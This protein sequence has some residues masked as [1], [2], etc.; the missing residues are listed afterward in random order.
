MKFFAKKQ[1]SSELS[2]SEIAQVITRY[3]DGDFSYSVN[4][5]NALSNAF[6]QLQQRL[7][8]ATPIENKP[9]TELYGYVQLLGEKSAQVSKHTMR[10]VDT[11][12]KTLSEASRRNT[13]L[14]SDLDA[15]V[16]YLET[17]N[18]SAEEIKEVIGEGTKNLSNSVIKLLESVMEQLNTK[19][20]KAKEVLS[21]IQEIGKGINLLALNAAI[22]AARAGEQGRGFAVVADEVRSL[23]SVTM[24]RAQQ[25]SEQLNFN[26]INSELEQLLESNKQTLNEFSE[27]I[28]H[29][30]GELIE[31]FTSI[32]TQLNSVKE[33][34][35]VISESIALSS[36]LADRIND[37]EEIASNLSTN[38]VTGIQ[39]VD[40][41]HG[42]INNALRYLGDSMEKMSFNSDLSTDRLEA[43]VQRGNIRVA[44]EP[45]FVGLSFR[46]N[47]TSSLS[48]LDVDYAH[49]LAKY[50]GVTCE[51]V[52]VPWDICT[53]ALTI[54]VNTNSPPADVIISAL[55]PSAEYEN[56]AYSETYTYLNWV[57]ARRKDDTSINGIED[58]NNKALG[59]IND[60]G[61]F[62]LL[63]NTGVRWPANKDKPGGKVFLSDLIAYSDQSRIHD[64][65]V[66]GTVDAFGVDLPIYH[67]ACTNKESPWLNKIEILPGHLDS[68]PYFYSMGVAEEPSSYRL[69]K[70]INEFISE[71]KQ[72]P[73]RLAI[74]TQWQG[75]VISGNIC[76]RDED[77][78]LAGEQQLKAMYLAECQRNGKE[79]PTE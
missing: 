20:S 66:D 12:R 7:S 5:D 46:K 60:P 39:R 16:L 15:T 72:S 24:D 26:E 9:Q 73:E 53:D 35:G 19:A 64:C 48:G 38:I 30:T 33:N 58:L 22:E 76:Y 52:E 44:I 43:I 51:F 11:Q 63:E 55:P 25:A 62:T 78:D 74:E 28:A 34:T 13:M 56:V 6:V 79:L 50:L 77:G 23:A 65:L 27:N 2:N 75:K 18:Q 40:T 29:I 71:F 49:C 21:G 41:Q 31:Q 8:T 68:T 45:E 17:S 3:L 36:G 70:K 4:S 32:E 61:A 14:N 69:L 37:K 10:A 59:I 57:L 42:D 67:W 1:P 47:S 54:G